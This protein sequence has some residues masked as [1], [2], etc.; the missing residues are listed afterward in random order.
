M[1]ILISS[2]PAHI[3]EEF[4]PTVCTST[5]SQFDQERFACIFTEQ[6]IADFNAGKNDFIEKVCTPLGASFALGHFYVFKISEI[7][8]L[9]ESS[10]EADHIHIYNSL[11]KKKSNNMYAIPVDSTVKEANKDI[12][13]ETSIV[14]GAFPC[15][16]DPRCP[17]FDLE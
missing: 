12:I 13:N 17:T 4:D 5:Y 6:M 8:A 7:K 14:L 11:D 3:P 16:P 2:S 15:P 10:P 9:I 1:A